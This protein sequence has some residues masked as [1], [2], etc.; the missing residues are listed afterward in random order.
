MHWGYNGIYNT[1]GKKDLEKDLS[2]GLYIA[3][4]LSK[5]AIKKES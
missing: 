5:K 2:I 1:E 4:G 3:S